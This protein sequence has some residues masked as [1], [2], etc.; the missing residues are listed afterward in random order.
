V[1]GGRLLVV[2]LV[3]CT[4]ES[5]TPPTRQV[6]SAD[7]V[8]AQLQRWIAAREARDTKTLGELVT[9]NVRIV[10]ADPEIGEPA[11]GREALASLTAVSAR[12][13]LELAIIRP[14]EAIALQHCASKVPARNPPLERSLALRKI[15]ELRFDDAGAIAEL[16]TWQD[17]PRMMRQ[18]GVA[19]D[20]VDAR[21]DVASG[22]VAIARAGSAAEA[23]NEKTARAIIGA[24][25]RRDAAAVASHVVDGHVEH[26]L[27]TAEPAVFANAASYERALRDE[28]A[29]CEVSTFRVLS[30][31][32][33]D[34]WIALRYGR[35]CKPAGVERHAYTTG[36]WLM[37]FTNGRLAESWR[38]AN[39]LDEWL[40]LGQLARAELQTRVQASGL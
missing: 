35:S 9:T 25:D 16:V 6:A 8:L 30:V 15:V 14:P 12:C 11:F 26:Q 20:D 21:P 18:V 32:A 34:A 27:A 39:R 33:A 23:G 10:S 28:L 24:L 36:L 31:V 2:A 37:R 17:D 38:A 22:R 5:T 1:S 7:R 3:A 40:Q 19:L 4:A 29:A 13:V